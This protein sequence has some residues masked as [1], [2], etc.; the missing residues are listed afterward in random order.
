MKLDEIIEGKFTV[1][2]RMNDENRKNHIE[3]VKYIRTLSNSVGINISTWNLFEVFG[4]SA[5]GNTLRTDRARI[6][7]IFWER[8]K[9]GDDTPPPEPVDKESIV[10]NINTWIEQSG[11]EF[12]SNYLQQL[13]QERDS[14]LT[15]CNDYLN[16]YNSY[17]V[18]VI[19][20]NKK[21]ETFADNPPDIG[22][23]ITK[24][25]DAGFFKF[26]SIT[27]GVITFTTDKIVNTDKRP[28]AGMDLTVE[29]GSYTIEYNL[30]KATGRRRN[31]DSVLRVLPNEDNIFS[32]RYYHPHI[33]PQGNICWG[34]GIDKAH[35]AILSHKISDAMT[36]LA[37]VLTH[38]NPE[39]PYVTL[40]NFE[41]AKSF[42]N[43]S[44]CGERQWNETDSHCM[45]CGY[46]GQDHHDEEDHHDEDDY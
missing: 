6:N 44:N 34:D 13:I 28:S 30:G 1:F 26:K 33:N 16:S 2:S 4:T 40:Y 5:G 9:A 42:I 46:N 17:L 37:A 19:H 24:V 3:T 39:D 23:E 25:I 20:K 35:Q 38:Y 14:A 18:E 12:K 22:G 8:F 36:I 11:R 43:C 10:T 31:R 32:G 45:N 15:Y 29:L 21:I 7:K 27:K 41:K